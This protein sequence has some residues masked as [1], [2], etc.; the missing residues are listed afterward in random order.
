GNLKKL[1]RSR[2]LLSGKKGKVAIN[3]LEPKKILVSR[4]YFKNLPAS[5]DKM[6][7]I[8]FLKIATKSSSVR[9]LIEILPF[10]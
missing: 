3:I 8:K 10:A 7:D 5:Q 1:D 4:G 2:F 9:F 6:I